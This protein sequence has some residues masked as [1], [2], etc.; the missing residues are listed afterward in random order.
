M[1]AYSIPTD[2]E[3]DILNIVDALANLLE[4]G[5]LDSFIASSHTTEYDINEFIS[6]LEA[7]SMTLE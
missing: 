3:R 5:K 6:A 4:S 1:Q 7:Y 2:T